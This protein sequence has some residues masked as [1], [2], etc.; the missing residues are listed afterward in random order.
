MANKHF[1]KGVSLIELTV[2]LAIFSI[3]MVIV[4]DAFMG[5]LKNS[6]ESVYEQNL[7]DHTEFLFSLMSKEIRMAKINYDDNS[8]S[9]CN[10]YFM[11]VPNGEPFKV[12]FNQTY[13]TS[14]D[15]KELRFINNEGKCVRYFLKQDPD[16]NN[17]T[18]LMISR[19]DKTDGTKS[20][21]VSPLAIQ[22]NDLKFS[23]SDL[24][25]QPPRIISNGVIH[26]LPPTV[27]FSMELKSELWT[28]QTVS[29]SNFIT[30]RNIEQF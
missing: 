10:D 14:S 12:P 17:I 28:P 27:Q 30:A 23:I 4:A 6:R 29:Y 22:V 11:N 16:N 1:P 7:Q 18:R 9:T 5:I 15:G 3:V 26:R 20:A 24:V 2:S 21:W 25:F 8:L 13:I 19:Y